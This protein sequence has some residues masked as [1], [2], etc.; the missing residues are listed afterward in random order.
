MPA[1]AALLPASAL[2]QSQTPVSLLPPLQ[3]RLRGSVKIEYTLARLG[4]ERFWKLIN[5]EP[6]VPAL[7][8]LTG[9]QAVQAVQASGPR[10]PSSSSPSSRSRLPDTCLS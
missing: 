1:A 5:D 10:P 6:Y 7:G 4:A 9:A 2:L 8:C 3:E